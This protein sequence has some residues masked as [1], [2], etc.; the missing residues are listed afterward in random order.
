MLRIRNDVPDPAYLDT[1][2]QGARFALFALEGRLR[3]RGREVPAELEEALS[4][5]HRLYE[6]TRSGLDA[7]E[8]KIEL[9]SQF[10]GK[11]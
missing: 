8:A 4:E 6:S 1:F 11:N 7:R 10:L 5:F 9:M 3:D 2:L